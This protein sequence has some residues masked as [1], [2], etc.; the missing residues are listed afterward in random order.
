MVAVVYVCRI[1]REINTRGVD[2][3]LAEE[4]EKLEGKAASRIYTVGRTCDSHSHAISKS[5]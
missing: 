2:W 4:E 1:Y 3:R 5:A